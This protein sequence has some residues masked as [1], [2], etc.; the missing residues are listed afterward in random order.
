MYHL[1]FTVK[2]RRIL[3][4]GEVEEVLKEV[5]LDIEKRY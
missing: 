4:D 5:C 3:F 1:V 2:Y